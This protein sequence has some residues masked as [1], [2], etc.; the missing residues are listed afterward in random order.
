M[1][2]IYADQIA[3]FTYGKHA[4]QAERCSLRASLPEPARVMFKKWPVWKHGDYGT[5]LST[6]FESSAPLQYPRP[7]VL[8]GVVGTD[9][10]GLCGH[11]TWTTATQNANAQSLYPVALPLQQHLRTGSTESRPTRLPCVTLARSFA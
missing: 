6:L 7:S 8:T 5:F 11:T 4:Q 10:R 1:L 9:K 3:L 2:Q